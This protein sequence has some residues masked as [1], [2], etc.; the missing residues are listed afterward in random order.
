MKRKSFFLLLIL[1]V[2]LII[3]YRLYNDLI[4]NFVYKIINPRQV[5]GILNITFY[6]GIII[7][8]VLIVLLTINYKKMKIQDYIIG[9]LSLIFLIS[10]IILMLSI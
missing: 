7:Q 5:E 4:P 1:I 9:I 8:I 3:K 2:C 6:L 10:F